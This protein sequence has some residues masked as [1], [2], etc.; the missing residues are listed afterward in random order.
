M[1]TIIREPP[2]TDQFLRIV[3]ALGENIVKEVKGKQS[4]DICSALRDGKFTVHW[5]HVLAVMA[6]RQLKI[7]AFGFASASPRR[8]YLVGIYT[9]QTGWLL[10]DLENYKQGFF[11]G[12]PVLL[13]KTPI[14][15]PFEGSR[16]RFW[17][18]EAAAYSPAPWGGVTAFSRTS[19]LGRQT[20][21]ELPN[22]TTEAK[23]FPLS[24]IC[25]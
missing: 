24:E 18:P 9:D 11:T 10:I 22:D 12:G 17:Y 23:S 3:R 6:A 20:P 25:K 4:E 19:W 7:P 1:Q 13:T 5:A 15:G 8:I 2:Y 14:I 16:H 21:S